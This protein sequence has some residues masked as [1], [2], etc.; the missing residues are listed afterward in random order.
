MLMEDAVLYVTNKAK[1]V[2]YTEKLIAA[3]EH[4]IEEL[5]YKLEDC[6]VEELDKLFED[7]F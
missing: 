5:I 7:V 6:S 3:Y 2:G 1:D 4:E